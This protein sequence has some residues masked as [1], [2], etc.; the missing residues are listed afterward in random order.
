MAMIPMR[1][2]RR[3]GL[4]SSAYYL[5]CYPIDAQEIKNYHSKHEIL[6]Q[7]N[8]SPTGIKKTLWVEDLA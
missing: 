6:T 1:K 7:A 5:R 2:P 8:Y 4:A 3:M